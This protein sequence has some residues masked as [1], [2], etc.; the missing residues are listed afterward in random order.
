MP[1]QGYAHTCAGSGTYVAAEAHVAGQIE[2]IS[3][4]WP[5]FDVTLHF[6]IRSADETMVRDKLIPLVTALLEDE[7]VE[8]SD[9]SVALQPQAA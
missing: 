2:E 3:T 5:R 8:H 7:L 6:Q 9:F 4:D 1:A